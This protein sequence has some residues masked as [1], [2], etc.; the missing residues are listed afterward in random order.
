M[1][2]FLRQPRREDGWRGRIRVGVR[3][4]G[5]STCCGAMRLPTTFASHRDSRQELQ[6]ARAQPSS[7]LS[8]GVGI[9]LGQFTEVLLYE[10]PVDRSRNSRVDRF[11]FS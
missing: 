6:P 3:S 11:A 8:E 7:P 9:G 4:T 2:L 5:S 1:T 10:Q